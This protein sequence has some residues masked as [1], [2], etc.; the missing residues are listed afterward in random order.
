M[1]LKSVKPP[2]SYS[3]QHQ[4]VSIQLINITNEITHAELMTEAHTQCALVVPKCFL[5]TLL[6]LLQKA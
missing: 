3:N 5:F 2:P 6:I 1:A 4:V